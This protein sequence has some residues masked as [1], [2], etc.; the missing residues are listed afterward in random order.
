MACR[1]LD[2]LRKTVSVVMGAAALLTATSTGSLAQ[3]EVLVF[4]AASLKNA[5]DGVIQSWQSQPGNEATVSYA[6]SSML[7]KQI[8]QGAPAD[9][10]ISADLAWMDYL[11]EQGLTVSESEQRL[12]GNRLALIAPA[13]SSAS[14]VIGA[15]FDLDGLVGD[16]RLAMANV[17]AVPAGR[18]GKAALE[19]LNVWAS[20][21][22]KVAQTDNV[23]A[24]L[25]LVAAGEAPLG[26]VYKTDATAEPAV[27]IIDIFPESSHPPVVYPIAILSASTNPHAI[28]LWRFFRS[29]AA[30]KHFEAQGFTWLDQ[31]AAQ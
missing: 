2:P 3:D 5:V 16:G 22:D 4:A 19:S 28:E 17:N 20:V 14:A 11:S 30:R 7:A 10:F 31:A 8:E 25:A 18:Y 24:T 29:P 12:L 23:R 21:A 13:G 6:G 15:G 1:Y 27:R 9:I 26:I